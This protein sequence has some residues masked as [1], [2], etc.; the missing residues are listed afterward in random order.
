MANPLSRWP[1]QRTMRGSKVQIE[2]AR[3]EVCIE[4]SGFADF[5]VRARVVSGTSVSGTG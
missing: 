4:N 2:K 3:Q 5:G 1:E